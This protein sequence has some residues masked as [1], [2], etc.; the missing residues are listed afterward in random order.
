MVA[1]RNYCFRLQDRK[2]SRQINQQT[3]ASLLVAYLLF[4]PEYGSNKLHSIKT[5]LHGVFIFVVYLK[6]V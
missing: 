3:S 5:R 2:L 1:C 4:K 6:R